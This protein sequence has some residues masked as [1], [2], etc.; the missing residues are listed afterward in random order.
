MARAAGLTAILHNEDWFTWFHVPANQI[1]ACKWEHVLPVCD[2]PPGSDSAYAV[3]VI[4]K[5]VNCPD[6]L[7]LLDAVQSQT[8]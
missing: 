7:V 6:C 5:H 4:H 3:F 8:P 2:A 1:S